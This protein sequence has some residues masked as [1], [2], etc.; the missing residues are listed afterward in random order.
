MEFPKFWSYFCFEQE[1]LKYNFSYTDPFNKEIQTSQSLSS[2]H[3]PLKQR[4]GSQSHLSNYQKAL[5][6]TR[7]L[8]WM[9]EATTMLLFCAGGR[10]PEARRA[11]DGGAAAG[12]QD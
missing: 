1:I 5:I 9:F 2:Q 12:W 11:A 10:A 7:L 6:Q 3:K 4:R 8:V